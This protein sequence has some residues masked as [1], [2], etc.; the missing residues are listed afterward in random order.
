MSSNIFEKLINSSPINKSASEVTSTGTSYDYPVKTSEE[1]QPFP[2][3]LTPVPRG[4][5][6]S[7]DF[8]DLTGVRRGRLTVVGYFRRDG[9]S[10]RKTSARW[11]CRCDCG[12]YT[13]R[14]SKALKSEKNNRDRCKECT[15]KLNQ[16]KAQYF[17]LTGKHLSDEEQY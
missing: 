10:E 14:K 7:S 8:T 11:S 1:D 13:L 4:M 12:T 2:H 15:H 3:K 16:R 5:S 6:M 9:G 17:K